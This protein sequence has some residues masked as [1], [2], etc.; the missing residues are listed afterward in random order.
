MN[1]K[2]KFFPPFVSILVFMEPAHQL[3]FPKKIN[4]FSDLFL[5]LINS[6]PQ[7]LQNLRILAPPFEDCF[8]WFLPQNIFKFPQINKFPSFY[9]DI[10]VATINT[11][12][13]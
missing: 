1:L 12:I 7:N 10:F 4:S 13:R 5:F 2:E 6:F 8:T 11:A 3:Q 9:T